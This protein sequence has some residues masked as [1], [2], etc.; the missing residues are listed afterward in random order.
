MALSALQGG[1]QGGWLRLVSG[2]VVEVRGAFSDKVASVQR[3]REVRESC[4][5]SADEQLG[6]A[7]ASWQAHEAGRSA[8]SSVAGVC[9]WRREGTGHVG[10]WTTGWVLASTATTRAFGFFVFKDWHLS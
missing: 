4:V 8:L 10:L 3:L 7:Q 9:R 1:Q 2:L 6:S 5:R